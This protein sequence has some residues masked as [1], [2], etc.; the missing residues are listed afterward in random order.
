[1]PNRTEPSTIPA[2]P[3]CTDCGTALVEPF[4]WCGNCRAAYCFGCGRSHFCSP[5][6]PVNGCLAG[7]CVRAVEDGRISERWGLPDDGP[8]SPPDLHILGGD[9]D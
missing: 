4:G 1:M 3:V 8:I 7:L 2:D 9:D 6:C 5:G